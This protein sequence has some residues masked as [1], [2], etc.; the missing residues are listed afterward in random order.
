MAAT[1]SAYDAKAVYHVQMDLEHLEWPHQMA[2]L[3][4]DQ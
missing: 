1:E 3:V 2:S 4:V